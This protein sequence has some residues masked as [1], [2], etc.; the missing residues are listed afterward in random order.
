MVFHSIISRRVLAL[1]LAGM[2]LVFCAVQTHAQNQPEDEGEHRALLIGINDYASPMINDLRGAVNDVQMLSRV[3]TTR[4][5]FAEDNIQVLTDSDATRD[6]ILKALAS[7]VAETQKNDTVYIH[8]S[9]HG[10]QVADANG[11]EPDQLD[12]TILPH[13]A[14]EPG[15]ADIIDDEIDRLLA[16]LATERALIVFDSCHSGTITRSESTVQLRAVPM[17][18]RSELYEQAIATRAIVPVKKLGHVLM[19]GAPA[20]Q[21]ALDGPVDNGYYGLFSYSLARSMDRHGPSGSPEQIHYGVKQELR[22]IQQQLNFQPPEP[23]LEASPQR[24]TQPLFAYGERPVKTAPDNFAAAPSQ[25]ALAMTARPPREA[26]RP[27]RRAWLPVEQKGKKRALLIDGIHLNA[28]PGSRWAIYPAGETRFA[29]GRALV[30]GIVAKLNGRNAV[31][32]FDRPVKKLP[33][34]ARAIAIAPPNQSA[35]ITLSLINVP[36]ERQRA[37][38][39]LI[40]QQLPQLR[41]VRPG[42]FARLSIAYDDGLWRALGA[43]GLQ[44][45]KVIA[46]RGNAD[47]ASQIAQLAARSSN[48]LAMISLDNP[49]SDIQ[50]QV[51][52]QTRPAEDDVQAR[53]LVKVTDAPQPGYRIRRPDEPRS[54]RNSLTVEVLADRPVYLNIVSIDTEGAVTVLFPNSYQRSN[55]YPQGL[56]PANQLVRIPDQLASGNRAGFHWD[57]GPPAGRDTLRV[58]ASED[59]NTARRIHAMVTE[60]AR[61]RSKFKALGDQLAGIHTR[62]VVVVADKGSPIGEPVTAAI[63]NTPGDWTA[64]SVVLN[65][66]Q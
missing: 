40:K 54:H 45:L 48:A 28:R 63:D 39:P 25:P 33:S 8:F 51:G 7:F 46:D 65:I 11:D 22:R 1:L 23:Q 60:A 31:L 50:L 29:P 5:G 41:F 18:S 12:E 43:G 37:L 26:K 10:S 27:A 24:I 59:I 9:G 35:D 61:D 62:G 47:L 56:I 4:M 17:D 13:D 21:Q 20:E 34:G 2:A 49:S 14:R 30:T 55:F 36:K 32:A 38:R 66:R 6:A 52:V 64:R 57:Y 44:E 3:L 19:T 53:G 58:F 42:Q 15:V 16:Q